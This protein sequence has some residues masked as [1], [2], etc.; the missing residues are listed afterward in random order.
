MDPE[1]LHA[2]A[3]LLTRGHRAHHTLGSVTPRD[4]QQICSI[5]SLKPVLQQMTS[6]VGTSAYCRHV[7]LNL[8]LAKLRKKWSSEEEAGSNVSWSSVSFKRA[9]VV[10]AEAAVAHTAGQLA[11]TSETLEN[12]RTK[13]KE[14]HQ[15]RVLLEAVT[16]QLTTHCRQSNQQLQ[17]VQ[18]TLQHWRDRLQSQAGASNAEQQESTINELLASIIQLRVQ[19]MDEDEAFDDDQLMQAKHRL[20][21]RVAE[22]SELSC[23][24]TSLCTL[25]RLART[26]AETVLT[27]TAATQPSAALH[28]IRVELQ[29][30]G[31][32]TADADRSVKEM[33]A[34]MCA[35]HIESHLRG[36]EHKTQ[37][38]AHLIARNAITA[39]LLDTVQH[40][41]SSPIISTAL[42][43]VLQS[44]ISAAGERAALQQ[45][46]VIT[47]RLQDEALEADQET[48]RLHHLQELTCAVEQSVRDGRRLES[49]WRVKES[50]QDTITE[51]VSDC[52]ASVSSAL[53]SLQSPASVLP[54]TVLQQE[55][56]QLSTLPMSLLRALKLKNETIVLERDLRTGA[57]YSGVDDRLRRILCKLTEKSG[58]CAQTAESVCASVHDAFTQLASLTARNHHAHHA[59]SLRRSSRAPA[60]SSTAIKVMCEEV[61]AHDEE[62]EQRVT[63]ALETCSTLIEQA[64]RALPRSQRAL[65]AWWDQP[66]K[67]IK[68]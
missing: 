14:E 51:T 50:S 27:L 30:K 13:L 29:E 58:G 9:A 64:R 44:S 28:A 1:K 37:A 2:W 39:H 21:S 60:L 31:E 68:L 53:V 20:W 57:V 3:D 11:Q 66:A 16:A 49:V 22:L 17:S 18:R 24:R 38:A 36:E 7:R 42:S 63:A 15:R 43:S 48:A 32:L 19:L 6:R 40:K 61:D 62:L 23:S 35:A 59:G 47:I 5:T 45:L 41:Y 4:F 34:L 56:Q 26:H 52:R 12:T 8:Q 25:T 54:L 55:M 33:L 46:H 67:K 65:V 10:K